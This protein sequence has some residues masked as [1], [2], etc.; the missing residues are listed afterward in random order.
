ME[1]IKNN[2][3]SLE[4]A[5]DL[6]VI[7]KSGEG[8]ITLSSAVNLFKVLNAIYKTVY[9]ELNKGKGAGK[10]ELVLT[11][12]GKGSV[13]LGL[14]AVAEN[15]SLF[16]SENFGRETVSALVRDIGTIAMG[17]DPE[18]PKIVKQLTNLHQPITEYREIEF[19][20]N[21]GTVQ[22]ATAD[23][24]FVERV[25]KMAEKVPNEQKMN[26][27]GTLSEGDFRIDKHKCILVSS[28]EGTI[29]CSFVP[30]L[31]EKVYSCLNPD[32]NNVV[33]SGIATLNEKNR[34]I[35]YQIEDIR[36][37]DRDLTAEEIAVLPP[38]DF[39][40]LIGLLSD[41][42]ENANEIVSDSRDILWGHNG[43]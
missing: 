27:L 2:N 13:S 40:P 14:N 9:T 6:E 39:E 4:D 37:Q 16:E 22:T 25:V 29:E 19:R 23:G 28:I 30:G 3:G 1:D 33:V 18:H 35:G 8:R 7:L 34:I 42:P 24:A 31:L 20:T 43:D 11:H 17:N 21:G 5:F 10:S 32:K 41:L 36:L 12:I 38:T 26:L 15:P